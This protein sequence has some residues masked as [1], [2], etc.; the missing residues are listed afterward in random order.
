[1]LH[2]GNRLVRVLCGVRY[3]EK[4]FRSWYERPLPLIHRPIGIKEKGCLRRGGLAILIFFQ[5]ISFFL[6]AA[7]GMLILQYEHNDGRFRLFAA[8]AMVI[9]F[10]LYYVTLGRLVL[11][12]SEAIV[13]FI[14]AGFWIAVWLLLRPFVAIFRFFVKRIEKKIRNLQKVIEKR[15]KIL[16]NKNRRKMLLK[17]ADEGFLLLEHKKKRGRTNE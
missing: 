10:F 9:G 11:L 3:S 16:Y 7:V 4:T 12:F 1:M 5:D 14:K 8:L 13:F 15:Q 6:V 17:Q 2:D